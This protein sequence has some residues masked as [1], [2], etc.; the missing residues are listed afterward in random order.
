MGLCPSEELPVKKDG[1]WKLLMERQF[2]AA[3][4]A[5]WDK[6]PKWPER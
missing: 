2:P 3:S 4:P 5:G 1:P 6:L